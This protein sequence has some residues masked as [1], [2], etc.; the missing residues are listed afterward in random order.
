[1]TEHLASMFAAPVIERFDADE[2][3]RLAA[4][5]DWHQIA[6]R[7]LAVYFDA[8]SGTKSGGLADAP[9]ARKMRELS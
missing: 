2:R 6:Q 1:L 4:R 9:S 5:H 3:A 8:L 7:T